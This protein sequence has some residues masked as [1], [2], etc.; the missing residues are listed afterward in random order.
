MTRIALGNDLMHRTRLTLAVILLAAGLV[1]I[2]Q[3]TGFLGGG[4]FMVG[5]PRWAWIGAATAIVGAILAIADV[6]SR[7][8]A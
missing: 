6:R 1:W 2:G 7:R 4:S 5:D 8:R 3:G